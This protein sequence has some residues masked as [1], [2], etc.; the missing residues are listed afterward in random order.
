VNKYVQIQGFLGQKMN[1]QLNQL[2][3]GDP[4]VK[5]AFMKDQQRRLTS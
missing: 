2:I 3:L 4:K 5:M 1:N